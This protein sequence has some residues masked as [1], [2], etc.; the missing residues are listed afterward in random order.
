MNLEELQEALEEALGTSNFTIDTDPASGQI[1]IYSG[2]QE[3]DD[4]ELEPYVNEDDEEDDDDL[5]VDPD[6]EPL[7]DEDDDSD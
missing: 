1:I 2:F 4:G 6:F 5:D 7:A 3:G